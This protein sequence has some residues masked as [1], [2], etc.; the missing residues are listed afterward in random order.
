MSELR[1]KNAC[2]VA[3]RLSLHLGVL[4]SLQS[5]LLQP[6]IVNPNSTEEAVANLCLLRSVTEPTAKRALW[7]LKGMD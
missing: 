6:M 4:R 5:C 1:E 3:F 2:V 7:G